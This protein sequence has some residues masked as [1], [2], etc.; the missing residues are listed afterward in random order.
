MILYRRSTLFFLAETRNM[1]SH[2]RCRIRLTEV[3]TENTMK[4]TT[5]VNILVA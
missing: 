4:L 5:L 2:N 1:L 3:V